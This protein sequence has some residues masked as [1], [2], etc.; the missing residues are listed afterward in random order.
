M[1]ETNP[2]KLK[3]WIITVAAVSILT[4]S[5]GCS[6]S[7]TSPSTSA[8][9]GTPLVG[10]STPSVG[11]STPSAGASTPLASASTGSQSNSQQD[12]DLTKKLLSEAVVQGGQVYV[13]QDDAVGVIMVKKGTDPKTAKALATKYANT[14]KKKYSTKKVNVHANIEGTE[15]AHI[16][17]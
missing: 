8:G 12:K 9:T 7:S 5:F 17:L 11:A 10:T 1:P 3:K 2:K 13:V 4:L 14:I 6:K 15:I 16:T